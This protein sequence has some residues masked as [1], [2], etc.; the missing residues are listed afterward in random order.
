MKRPS[1]AV[2]VTLILL[3]HMLAVLAAPAWAGDR[4]A[5]SILAADND[6]LDPVW[7]PAG[8][9]TVEIAGASRGQRMPL[10]EPRCLQ[11]RGVGP[12]RSACSAAPHPHRSTYPARR[13]LHARSASARAGDHPH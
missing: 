11:A 6:A 13:L 8:G 1:G 4:G 5:G 12:R 9:Y 7:L 3:L 2:A 10:P